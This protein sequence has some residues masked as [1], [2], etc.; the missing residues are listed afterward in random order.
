MNSSFRNLSY[1]FA[2]ATLNDIEYWMTKKK[3]PNWNDKNYNEIRFEL[4]NQGTLFTRQFAICYVFY[5][6]NE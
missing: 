2:K 6:D 4:C 3:N 5:N 1:S